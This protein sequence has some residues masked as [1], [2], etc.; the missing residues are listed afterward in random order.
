[1]VCVRGQQQSSLQ[2]MS[3]SVPLLDGPNDDV[4]T[5]AMVY[6][7]LAYG[8]TWAVVDLEGALRVPWN[9]PFKTSLLRKNLISSGATRPYMQGRKACHV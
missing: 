7:V 8:C 6:V 4:Q 3:L 5:H 2:P 9:P 1:M